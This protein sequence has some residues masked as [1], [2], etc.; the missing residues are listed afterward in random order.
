MKNRLASREALLGTL[1]E[2]YNLF[3][4]RAEALC[5]RLVVS[6]SVLTEGIRVDLHPP[7]LCVFS[8]GMPEAAAAVAP[9]HLPECSPYS[10]ASRPRQVKMSIKSSKAVV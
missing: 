6:K 5:R 9:P 8:T 10:E 2:G 7:S 4:I 3:Q 1:S